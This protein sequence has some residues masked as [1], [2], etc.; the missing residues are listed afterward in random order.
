MQVWDLRAFKRPLCGLGGLPTLWGNTQCC[1]SPD[2]RLLATGTSVSKGEDT[3][4]LVF[5][6]W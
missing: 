4:S 3:G 6:D 1:F 2:E 5:Y